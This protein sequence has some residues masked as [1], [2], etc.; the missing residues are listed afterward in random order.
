MDTLYLVS[1]ALTVLFQELSVV[2][3][4]LSR[5]IGTDPSKKKKNR[6]KN[7]HPCMQELICFLHFSI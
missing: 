2:G 7:I 6:F 4:E 5:Q 3:R 1:F